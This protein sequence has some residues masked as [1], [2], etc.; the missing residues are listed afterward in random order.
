MYLID[1]LALRAGNE[2]DTN[3]EAD[4]VGCC[5]LHFEHRLNTH[6]SSYMI[7][8]TAK[9]FHTFNVSTTFQILLKKLT[10]DNTSI[11]EKKNA[12]DQALQQ[13]YVPYNDESDRRE[14]KNKC[15]EKEGS[16]STITYQEHPQYTQQVSKILQDNKIFVAAYAEIGLY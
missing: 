5:S 1:L 10:N 7:G 3:K 6:L 12:H 8:L 13:Y 16:D 15:I 11:D 9:V 14:D 2:K 4:T